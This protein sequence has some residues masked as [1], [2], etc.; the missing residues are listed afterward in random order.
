VCE[1]LDDLLRIPFGCGVSGHIEVEHFP[2]AMLNQQEHEQD[3]QPDGRNSKEVD[4]HDLTEMIAKERFPGLR[5]GWSAHTFRNPRDGSLLNHNA[6]H[7]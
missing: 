7:F 3:A 4:R 6:E 2:A 1:R 5:R